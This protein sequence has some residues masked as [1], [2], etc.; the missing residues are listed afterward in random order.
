M[1]KTKKKLR[2]PDTRPRYES[3]I[4]RI[5]RHLSGEKVEIKRHAAYTLKALVPVRRLNTVHAPSLLAAL[6]VSITFVVRTDNMKKI[7]DNRNSLN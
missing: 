1:R 2:I 5:R 3:Q 4:F 7:S 6:F